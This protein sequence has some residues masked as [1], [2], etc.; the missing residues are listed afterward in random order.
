MNV[1]VIEDDR[2]IAGL[3]ERGLSE[4]GHRVSISGNGRQGV[5]MM[6]GGEYDAALLDILPSTRDGWSRGIGAGAG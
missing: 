2:K 6:I 1:L 4:H 3:L 5:E